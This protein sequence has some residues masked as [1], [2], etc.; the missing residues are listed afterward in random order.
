MGIAKFKQLKPLRK[1]TLYALGIPVLLSQE[2]RGEV[3]RITQSTAE[4]KPASCFRVPSV[5]GPAP[6]GG[7]TT[8]MAGF[9]IATLNR[10][11]REINGMTYE[12][13]RKCPHKGADLTFVSQT[14]VNN[15]Q[16]TVFIGRC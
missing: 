11:R 10:V 3:K 2:L 15:L 6:V 1:K 5:G 7:L 12:Y 9:S 16:V 8:E 14:H 13:D 4:I